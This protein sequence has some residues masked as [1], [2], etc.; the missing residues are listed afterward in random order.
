[1]KEKNTCY[2]CGC[3]VTEETSRHLRG[4]TYCEDCYSR[5]TVVCDS[6][7]ERIPREEAESDGRIN[8]CRGCYEDYYEV[9]RNCGEFVSNDDVIYC[10]DADGYYCE[11]C[12]ERLRSRPIKSYSYK[13]EPIFYGS[14][15]LFMGVELEIDNAGEYDDN[16]KI[17]LD[18]ANAE[19]VKMYIKHDGSL[20]QGMELVSHP[21]SLEYH[22]NSMCW[23][24]V[25]DKAL[26]LDYRSHQTNTCGLHIHVNRS[27]FGRRYDEIEA[28]I[29][30][31]VHFVEL[32]WNEVLHF[33]RR[34]EANINRWASRYGITPTVK[35]TYDKAKNSNLGRYV[36]VNLENDDTIEFRMFR[37]TL[38]YST[39]IATLQLVYEICR[40]AIMLTDKELEN[41]SW[42][43]FVST[44]DTEKTELIEYLKAKRLYVNEITTETEEM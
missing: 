15:N 40:F 24:D 8:L 9:C 3:E 26:E 6:C 33:S 37:G 44:I 29:G 35:E 32:H 21:M 7:G 34:T 42:S 10:E 31:V 19:G 16:A 20:S 30:R 25:F 5:H 18:V 39:F 43:E 14:G 17:L 36:A 41:M 12:Y 13:P 23:Q 4:I 11:T 2:E 1:M 38:R 28:A 22:R 27:A